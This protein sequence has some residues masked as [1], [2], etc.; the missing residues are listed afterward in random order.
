MKKQDCLLD[1]PLDARQAAL[2]LPRAW[3]LRQTTG[4]YRVTQ[5][6]TIAVSV[7]VVAN[8]TDPAPRRF[9]PEVRVQ[10]GGVELPCVLN[11]RWY[12]SASTLFAVLE[13]ELPGLTQ[14]T[15]SVQV[16]DVTESLPL[17]P[18]P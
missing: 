18:A 3:S 8:R 7:T 17:L 11:P 10:A 5:S 15:A 16:D 1:E 13:A 2:G 12:G 14:F 9:P 4:Q 6:G